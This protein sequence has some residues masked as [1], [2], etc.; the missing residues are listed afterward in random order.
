VVSITKWREGT[1]WREVVVVQD[2]FLVVLVKIETSNRIEDARPN[3]FETGCRT[4]PPKYLTRWQFP[5]LLGRFQTHLPATTEKLPEKA[6]SVFYLPL[7]T[8]QNKCF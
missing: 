1:C 8:P 3:S 7:K 6:F 5:D 4:F 2:P